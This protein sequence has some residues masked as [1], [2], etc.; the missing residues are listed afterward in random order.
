MNVGLLVIVLGGSALASATQVTGRELALLRVILRQSMSMD[1]HVAYEKGD[2][3]RKDRV[4]PLGLISNDPNLDELGKI[5]TDE[6]NDEYKRFNAARAMAFFGDARCI[7]ILTKTL[8]GEF[9]VSSSCIEQSHA[10]ACLLYLGYEFP[11]D[12][13]FTR[14]PNA[15]YGE[16]NALLDDPNQTAWPA[17]MYSERYNYSSDPNLP[18]TN[19]EVGI[20]V[21][22]ALGHPIGPVT[23]RGPLWIADVEQRELQSILDTAAERP[24]LEWIRIPLWDMRDEWLSFKKRMSAGGLLYYF[25][26]D[27]I[28]WSMLGGREGYVLIREDKVAEMIVTGWN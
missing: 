24:P 2:A 20:L 13:L 27:A 18:I 19:E 25:T 10:A 9:A 26:T 8:A 7:D 5:M 12:F 17:A 23:A 21:R 28:D 11:K 14:L 1:Q 4:S 22:K 15:Q 3:L 6:A 16:L